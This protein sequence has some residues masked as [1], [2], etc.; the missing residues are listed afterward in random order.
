LAQKKKKEEEQCNKRDAL[1][2]DIFPKESV[3]QYIENPHAKSIKLN[4]SERPTIKRSL[5][6]T[7]L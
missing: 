5:Q 1:F 7:Y 6:K 3:I 2:N 4:L